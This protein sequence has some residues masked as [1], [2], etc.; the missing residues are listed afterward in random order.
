MDANELKTAFDLAPLVFGTAGIRSK[1][2]PGTQY[3]NEFTYR[4]IA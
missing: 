3:L 1:M 2:G 4:Q